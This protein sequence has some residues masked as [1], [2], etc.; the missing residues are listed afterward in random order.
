MEGGRGGRRGE[1]E[2]E[3]GKGGRDQNEKP[4][5]AKLDYSLWGF[6]DSRSLSVELL[7]L[8]EEVGCRDVII[9]PLQ[10]EWKVIIRFK[11]MGRGRERKG[12]EEGGEEGGNEQRSLLFTCST[13]LLMTSSLKS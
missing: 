8:Q 4:S 10:R 5:Y 2:G 6:D 12:G 7:L 1:R 3:G 9:L 11:R 13:I